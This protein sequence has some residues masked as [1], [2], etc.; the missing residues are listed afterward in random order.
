MSSQW[1]EYTFFSICRFCSFCAAI[2]ANTIFTMEMPE[3]IPSVELHLE[4]IPNGKLQAKNCERKNA[5][6]KLR[7]KNCEQKNASKKLQT[8]NCKQKI[9][10]EKLQI[11]NVQQKISVKKFHLKLFQEEN[12]SAKQNH[13]RRQTWKSKKHFWSNVYIENFIVQVHKF[14]FTHAN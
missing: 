13:V 7:A 3:I 9:P 6:K 2:S 8:K 14:F 1:N 4:K 5:N 12:D 11:K 10:N